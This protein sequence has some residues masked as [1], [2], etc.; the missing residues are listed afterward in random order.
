[1]FQSQD[2]AVAQSHVPIISDLYSQLLDEQ[3]VPPSVII[4][5]WKRRSLPTSQTCPRDDGDSQANSLAASVRRTEHSSFR[6]HVTKLGLLAT[7][8]AL[9][10]HPW[11]RDTA[12]LP[13]L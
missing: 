2:R 1:M 13:T 7:L 6:N 9:L 10:N 5:D 3:A 4:G 8:I 11:K 12:D